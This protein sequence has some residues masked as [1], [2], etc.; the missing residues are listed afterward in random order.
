MPGWVLGLCNLCWGVQNESP[1]ALAQPAFPHHPMQPSPT[2]WRCY[3]AS[4]WVQPW[5]GCS[6]GR[7]ECGVGGSP[8]WLQPALGTARVAAGATCSEEEI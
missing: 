2:R 7:P 6:V 1:S 5:R 8:A 4:A 3:F